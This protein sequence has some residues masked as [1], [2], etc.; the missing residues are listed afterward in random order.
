M[1]KY[2]TLFLISIMLIQSCASVD[3]PEIKKNQLKSKST[4]TSCDQA[5]LRKNT[6]LN[7]YLSEKIDLKRKYTFSFLDLNIREAILEIA[8]A[9][10]VP[11]IL[12]ENVT[13]I[14]TVN[15]V[16]MN[17]VEIMD[18]ITAIGPFDYIIK[19]HTIYVGVADQKALSYWKLVQYY[20]YKTSF[21]NP[22]Q[23][24]NL[25]DPYMKNYIT[26]DDTSRIVHISAS[27]KF[28]KQIVKT[29]DL[30]DSPQRQI[31]LSLIV[32]EVDQGGREE[33]GRIFQ[34]KSGMNLLPNSFLSLDKVKSWK[35]AGIPTST[36]FPAN[37][38]ESLMS[39]LA[40]LT[41]KGLAKIKTQPQIV[42]NEGVKAQFSSSKKHLLR[43]AGG[44]IDSKIQFLEAGVLLNI[45]PQ[46]VNE[47]EI[48]LIITDSTVSTFNE[49]KEE[50][51]E[52]K[53]STIVRVKN[54]DS[55]VFGGLLS[56]GKT[57]SITKIPYLSNLPLVG[58]FFQNKTESETTKEVIFAIKSE[59]LCNSQK[60]L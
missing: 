11:I 13:G 9:S 34:S 54:G 41:E 6:E 56:Q 50:I 55:L 24:V 39:S 46:I 10:E 27:G 37:Q 28:L 44:Y 2:H 33:I 47:N 19:E 23:L 12:D 1:N 4:K 53:I 43:G 3:I 59:I 26:F 30:I 32:T 16:N 21:I 60:A 52:H 58:W 31:L 22:S 51:D 48:L 29:L 36:V 38:A 42:I 18:V 20:D 40:F 8:S 49:E 57:I 15:V 45:V 25:L 17:L 7:L 5:P 14:V 35:S